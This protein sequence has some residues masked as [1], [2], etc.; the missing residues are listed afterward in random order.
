M[1]VTRFV[2][3]GTNAWR[4]PAWTV[5]VGGQQTIPVGD[6][7]LMLDADSQYRSSRYTGFD[8][9][10]QEY[11]GHSWVTNASVSF[12][13]KDGKY[14]IGGFVRN[15]TDMRYQIYGAPVPGSNLIT[16]IVSPPRTYGVR[17]ST[18]F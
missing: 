4:T 17:L 3:S 13:A 12:G 8:Y 1:P 6:Y 15:I 16:E 10:P 11:V 2:V 18:R 9:I 5:N 7:R 14:I